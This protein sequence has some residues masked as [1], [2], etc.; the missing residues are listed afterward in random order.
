MQF[1]NALEAL[2]QFTTVVADTGSFESLR[3]YQPQDATTNPTLII[4]ALDQPQYAGIIDQVK[5]RVTSKKL[6]DRTRAVLTAFGGE[7]LKI[8]P[9]R[10][11][12]EVDARLSFDT[13]ATVAEAQR[14]IAGYKEQ[15][16]EKSRVL[17][18]VA[19]TWEGIRAV[20]EL[21]KQGIACNVTLIFSL[22][23]AAAA[24]DAGATLISPFVGRISDW[25][26][27]AGTVWESPDQDPG[28]ISV[29]RIYAYL[30][31]HRFH[32]EVM[33][34]SFRNVDQILA[35]AGCDLLTVSPEL[36]E[37]LKSMDQEA[38]LVRAL[39]PQAP[40]QG[41]STANLNT[42]EALFRFSLNEDAMATEKLSEGIRFFVSDARKLD[43]R[44]V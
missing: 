31:H 38:S 32:T 14:I 34:A 18:K 9:G 23:Q 15:G 2:R 7:I 30:K 20:R 5:S 35:L 6:A 11:S 16:I 33:G 17:I 44:L 28:V 10:V 13:E 39:D 25:H 1:D 3:A 22:V 24:A 37:Q 12:T 36:L 27:K 19:A 43:A 41:Q 8:I 42:S 4:R 40:A 29:K 26:K 21:E